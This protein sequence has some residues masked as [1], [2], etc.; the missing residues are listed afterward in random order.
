V[1]QRRRDDDSGACARPDTGKL[2]TG[3]GPQW[4]ASGD[5]RVVIGR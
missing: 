1:W 5:S 4:R 2:A 3:V